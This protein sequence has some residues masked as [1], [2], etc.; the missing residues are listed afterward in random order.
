[1]AIGLYDRVD[2]ALARR[3]SIEIDVA[4]DRTD[5]PALAGEARPDLVLINDEDLT[6]AKIRLDDH[7][8]ATL[9]ES[10]G[11][12]TDSLPAALCWAAAYD[13]CRDAEMPARD[14]VRL[15]LG[16]VDSVRDI[17]V[18]QT[19]LRQATLAVRRLADPAWRAEGRALMA[20]S[21]R[22]LLRS[23]APGSD[24][25]LAYARAFAAV[26]SSS[27]D[28][29]L[30]SGLLDGSA[31]IEGLTVDTDLR[32]ILLRRLVSQG[33]A[34]DTAIDAELASDSTDAGERHAATCRAAI[35]TTEGKRD[36]WEVLTSG[37]LTIAM[38]R[39]VLLGFADPDADELLEPYAPAYFDTVGSVWRDWSSAMAQDF[40]S[41]AYAVCPVSEETVAATDDYLAA[42]HPPAALHRLLIEGRD[43]V[44]RSLRCQARDRESAPAS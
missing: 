40:V 5:V 39:A 34:G 30:L 21:L 36:T 11:A 38:F 2:G 14:Y 20:A 28:L 17:S 3:S 44:L 13:M 42:S 18:V 10:I 8:L 19:L 27:D 31:V 4:G 25:Q 1:V 43:E 9:V 37:K 35:P 15:V 12:F 6:Y 32:W 7:S 41:G 16:G 23:A 24:H 29:A 33:V 22:T 26:A